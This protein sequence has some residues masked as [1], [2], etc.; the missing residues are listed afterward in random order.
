MIDQFGTQIQATLFKEAVDKHAAGLIEGEVYTITGGNIKLANQRFCSIKNDFALVLDCQSEIKRCIDDFSI[1]AQA[2]S[3]TSLSQ[4]VD[5]VG[6][7]S[8][9]FIGVVHQAAAVRDK[10]LR[11]GGIKQIRN[12]Y[13]CDESKKAIQICVWGN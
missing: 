10:T 2:Y 7:R 9:D 4:I 12:F 8:V 13:L 3:F 5:S 11:N 1:E 6:M